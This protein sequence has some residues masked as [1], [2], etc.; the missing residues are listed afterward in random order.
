MRPP[1]PGMDPWLESP[2]IWPGVHFRLI[3]SIAD[4]L[5]IRL[6]PRYFVNVESRTTILTGL[7]V[8]RVYKPDVTI[9]ATE[10]RAAVPG[11]GVAVLEATD[12]QTY[13]VS[14]PTSEETEETRSED[15]TP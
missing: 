3:T 15:V 10:S 4:N 11:S 1:F 5:A 13:S 14:V 2:T 8:D 6:R 9:Q 7:D 12:V